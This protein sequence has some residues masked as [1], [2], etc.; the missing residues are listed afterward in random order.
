MVRR[1]LGGAVIALFFLPA[2]RIS[3]NIGPP[4]KNAIGE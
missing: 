3:Y 2:G 4:A 1:R